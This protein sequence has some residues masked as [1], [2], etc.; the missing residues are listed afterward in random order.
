MSENKSSYNPPPLEIIKCAED[1]DKT[2]IWN[3]VCE[4]P[5]EV[6]KEITGGRMN[7]KTDINP[8]YRLKRLTELFGPPGKGWYTD[9]VRYT[10]TDGGVTKE[11]SIEC[12]L[13]LYVKYDGLDGPWSAPIYGVGGNKVL[14]FDKN[15]LHLD[16][17]ARKKAYTD[18]VSIACK[19]IGICA[20]VWFGCDEGKYAKSGDGSKSKG[21]A[22]GDDLKTAFAKWLTP[23]E[24]RNRNLKAV[25]DK[26]N[27]AAGNPNAFVGTFN[28]LYEKQ[29]F[30]KNPKDMAPEELASM[31][32]TIAAS[33]AVRLD[34][35]SMNK[36][37]DGA[38]K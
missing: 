25:M 27:T 38:G 3:M 6:K 31:V 4:T 16:D 9:Q 14:A 36:F 23:E 11:V 10:I 18:A 5:D 15:G 30:T 37:L 24:T 33:L 35:P 28:Q 34:P 32:V 22:K 7:G 20:D 26:I 2:R 8:M 1:N 21:T 29:V 12:E 13:N 19:A 17:D